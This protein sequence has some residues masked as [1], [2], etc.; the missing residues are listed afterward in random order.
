MAYRNVLIDTNVCIDAIQQRE[1]FGRVAAIL[2]DHSEKGLING[3]VS[4]HSFDTLF[5]ILIRTTQRENV[6]QAIRGLRRTVDIAPVTKNEIDKALQHNWPD[7]EDAIHYE[8]ARTAGC[9]A[10]VTRNTKDFKQAELPVF[11]PARF[12]EELEG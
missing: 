6:Y 8:A 10:I 5:Y 4:A 1:P 9:D 3:Y 2:L 12:L 7:F 11:S